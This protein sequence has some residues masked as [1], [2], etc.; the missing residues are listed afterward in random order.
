MSVDLANSLEACGYLY[1]LVDLSR[2]SRKVWISSRDRESLQKI[3]M[4]SIKGGAHP[5]LGASLKK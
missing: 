5:K 1:K 3:L 4:S 2:C